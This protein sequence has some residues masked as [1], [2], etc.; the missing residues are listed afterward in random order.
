MSWLYE[1]W[2]RY[3]AAALLF[4]RRTRR[5]QQPKTLIKLVILL[6]KF[7][8][9]SPFFTVPHDHFTN[10]CERLWEE[11]EIAVRLASGTVDDAS[12]QLPNTTFAVRITVSGCWR[13]RRLLSVRPQ[14]RLMTYWLPWMRWRRSISR[15]EAQSDNVC[16]KFLTGTAE[17]CDST[18][19]R[20]VALVRLFQECPCHHKA[21][22]VSTAMEHI[23]VVEVPEIANNFFHEE[24]SDWMSL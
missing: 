1:Q 13:R 24:R 20:A 14:R 16:L 2:T 23:G 17:R 7:Y 8:A 12:R 4:L 10:H 3:D 15:L 6:P 11:M 22:T 21:G 9:A 18:G 5:C 19:L